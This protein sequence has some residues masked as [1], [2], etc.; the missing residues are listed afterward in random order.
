MEM[1]MTSGADFPPE[2]RS[3]CAEESRRFVES[4][5]THLSREAKEERLRD[6]NAGIV[7]LLRSGRL[8]K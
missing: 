1:V 8:Q 6:F 5:T 4:R 7:G 3:K 2:R